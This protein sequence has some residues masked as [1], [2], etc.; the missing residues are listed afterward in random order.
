[1]R[2]IEHLKRMPGSLGVV[3]GIMLGVGPLLVLSVAI[4]NDGWTYE[5]NP[6]TY[7]EL[8]SSG[9]GPLFASLGVIM[10]VMGL[11]FYRAQ[12][13]VRYVVPMA[14]PALCIA[15]FLICRSRLVP[16]HEF[17]IAGA[18]IV[19]LVLWLVSYRYFFRKKAVREYFVKKGIAE[20]P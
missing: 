11:A 14:F 8:W 19:S 10:T 16:I 20:H 1:M 12:R 4:P 7:G 2:I 17:E 6:V 9:G 18:C 15:G 5:G 13:W 3:T